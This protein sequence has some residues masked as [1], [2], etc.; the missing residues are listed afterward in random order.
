[1]KRAKFVVIILVIVLSV[2]ALAY[3]QRSNSYT[4]DYLGISFNYF[5]SSQVLNVD[6]NH[7]AIVRKTET[8]KDPVSAVIISGANDSLE[9]TAEEWLLGPNSGFNSA[10]SSY[11]NINIA[12]QDGVLIDNTWAIVKTPDGNWR[13]SVAILASEG[14][15]PMQEEFNKIIKSLTFKQL[16]KA[17][18]LTTRR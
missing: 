17:L 12:G 11:G 5:D 4:S 3:F 8:D 2:L 16:S 6:E 15:E 9:M 18:W 10:S 7:L 14:T 13:I 1:M